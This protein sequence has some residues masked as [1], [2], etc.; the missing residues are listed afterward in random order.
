MRYP[1]LLESGDGYSP[2]LSKS[3]FAEIL[4]N[5]KT[6]NGLKVAR[7]APT[8]TFFDEIDSIDLIYLFSSKISMSPKIVLCRRRRP[9]HC[10]PRCRFDV[11]QAPDY[12]I[13]VLPSDSHQI[14]D[15]SFHSLLLKF[16]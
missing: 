8:L 16:V 14:L 3:G 12:H 6:S 13:V 10:C 1:P 11:V 5:H 7:M 4:L 2:N 9:R 15:L